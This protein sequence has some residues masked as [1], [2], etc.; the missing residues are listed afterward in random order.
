[1]NAQTVSIPDPIFLNRLIEVGVDTNGDGVIQQSEAEAISSLSVSTS[2]PDPNKIQSLEG[3]QYFI[4]LSSL[5]CQGNALTTLDVTSLTQLE[6]LLCQNNQLSSIQVDGLSQLERIW[7]YSN[8]LT[9][10]DLSGLT[11]MWF[12]W[13]NNNFIEDLDLSDLISLEALYFGNNQLSTIDF[14]QTQNLTDIDLSYNNLSEVDV[15]HLAD[16]MNFYISN[17]ELTTI[18]LS[19]LDALFALHI[20]GNLIE[21]IDGTQNPNF[22]ELYCPSN[23]NLNYIN[24]KNGAIS[25]SSPDSMPYFSFDFS[26]LPALAF[27]CID[28][29]EEVALAESYYVAENVEVSTTNCAFSVSDNYFNEF[30]FYPNPAKDL[31]HMESQQNKID[32]IVIYNLN[33]KQVLNST[34]NENQPIDVSNLAKGMYLVKVQTE[35]GSLTKKLIKD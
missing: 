7:A 21:N 8:Q 32:Q 29:G 31:L 11:N 19:G 2:V 33:G 35:N 13:L 4:N 30:T 27:V 14:S 22:T 12:I 28:E 1:M 5:H 15:N 3:I 17:N 23:P 34:Y 10:I 24:M 16:L 6:S 18:D 20:G 9:E 26:N 25:Y